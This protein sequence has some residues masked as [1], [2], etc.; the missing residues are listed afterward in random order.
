M[1][2][3]ALLKQRCF[4]ISM[5]FVRLISLPRGKDLKGRTCMQTA[6][7]QSRKLSLTCAVLLF[8]RLKH[9]C[10]SSWVVS[11]CR[12]RIIFCAKIPRHV[13]NCCG[14]KK[15]FRAE[16]LSFSLETKRCIQYNCQFNY[17]YFV[18][19]SSFV[20]VFCHCFVLRKTRTNQTISNV[21]EDCGFQINNHAV[22]STL[23]NLKCFYVN[24]SS[25]QSFNK[26]RTVIREYL[27]RL[28]SSTLAKNNI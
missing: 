4:D 23:H 26:Y 8:S 12:T 7:S 15:I 9:I 25:Y 10:I 18:D 27:V 1:S 6:S 13:T 20:Q 5:T 21:D 14:G 28:F 22:F 17:M 16:D 24:K 3:D 2:V 11:L 19:L